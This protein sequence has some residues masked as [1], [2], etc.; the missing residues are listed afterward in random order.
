MAGLGWKLGSKNWSYT[1]AGGLGLTLGNTSPATPAWASS[2]TLGGVELSNG[3]SQG[4]AEPGQWQY[5]AM[6]GALD[7]TPGGAEGGFEYGPAAGTSVLRY[8]LSRRLTLESQVETAPSMQTVG[9]GGTY[10]THQWGAWSAG[11]A[12]ATQEMDNGMRYRVG[13]QASLLGRLQFSW[14]GEHRSAG[15]SDLSLYRSLADNEAQTSNLWKV[16]VPLDGYGSVSGSYRAV[17]TPT[18]APVEIFG[19]SHQ[20]ALSQNV[21]LALQAQRQ[22]YTGDYDVGLRLSIPTN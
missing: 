16:T 17:E 4:A 5:A 13:Y 12:R 21:K 19:V 20:F 9:L 8:G 7:Y 6:V 14:V 1:S 2:T 18:G 11:V 10:D 22:R 3:L 15:F